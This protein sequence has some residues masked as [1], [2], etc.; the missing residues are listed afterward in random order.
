MVPA[1]GPYDA[2]RKV[3]VDLPPAEAVEVAVRFTGYRG[4]YLIHC[5]NVEHEDMAMIAEFRSE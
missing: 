2:G 3:T 1:P 5:H 4:R